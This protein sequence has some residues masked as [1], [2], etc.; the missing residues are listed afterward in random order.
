MSIQK[1]FADFYSEK[2]T[3]SLLLWQYE[4]SFCELQGI[5]GNSKVFNKFILKKTINILVFI[6]C[7]NTPRLSFAGF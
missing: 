5:F 1:N 6:H 7:I 3:G 4:L 2:Q